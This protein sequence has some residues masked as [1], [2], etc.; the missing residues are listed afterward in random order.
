M[1]EA[2]NSDKNEGELEESIEEKQ[3][4]ATK[5]PINKK[6]FAISAFLDLL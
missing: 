4:E 3:Y 1:N 5:K 6:L 2:I